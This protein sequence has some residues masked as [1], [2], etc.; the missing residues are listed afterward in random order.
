[1][2]VFDWDMD[3]AFDSVAGGRGRGDGRVHATT[4]DGL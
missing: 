3:I 1:M 2:E 4:V